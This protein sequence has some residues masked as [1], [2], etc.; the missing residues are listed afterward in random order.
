MLFAISGEK[1]PFRLVEVMI[2]IE[3]VPA[4]AILQGQGQQTERFVAIADI[5]L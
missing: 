5:L 3:Q 4:N 2:A 1:L